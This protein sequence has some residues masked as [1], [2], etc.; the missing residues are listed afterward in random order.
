M[1]CAK[2]HEKEATVHLTTIVEGTEP[3]SIDLCKDCAPDVTGFRSFDPKVLRALS[4]IGKKC[5]FC[6]K[7]AVSG[8]ILAG[9]GAIYWCS[10]CGLE[11]GRILTDL[12]VSERPDLMARIKGG[13]S[14]FGFASDPELKAWIEA[15]HER[16]VRILKD[17]RK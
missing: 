17:R 12:A 8:E 7:D 16:V 10:D 3:E 1:L 9:G 14:F 11:F 15:A 13:S 4:A 6:G 5:E 2:C